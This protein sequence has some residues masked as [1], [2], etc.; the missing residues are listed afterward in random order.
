MSE[1]AVNLIQQA[2]F[3]WRE[4]PPDGWVLLFVLVGAAIFFVLG[5]RFLLIRKAIPFLTERGFQ[6]TAS[7][8]VFSNQALGV[9]ARFGAT[10]G[11]ESYGMGSSSGFFYQSKILSL[12]V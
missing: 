1:W 11:S 10:F 9:D 7:P 6:T 5:Q 8:R 12:S 4:M 2:Q 3:I